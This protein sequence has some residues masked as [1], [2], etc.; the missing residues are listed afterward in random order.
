MLMDDDNHHFVKY[1]TGSFGTPIEAIRFHIDAE[2]GME[3]WGS[4]DRVAYNHTAQGTCTIAARPWAGT[5]ANMMGPMANRGLTGWTPGIQGFVDQPG[6]Y[7]L[8]DLMDACGIYG[9]TIVN[10][11]V[12]D[13]SAQTR[14]ETRTQVM[15]NMRWIKETFGH[16]A[17]V[18]V[19]YSTRFIAIKSTSGHDHVDFE[20]VDRIKDFADYSTSDASIGINHL[21]FEDP[22]H[23]RVI[24]LNK[25]T[26]SVAEVK[27]LM[28][29]ALA[30]G[31]YLNI[32]FEYVNDSGDPNAYSIAEFEE[33][34]DYGISIGLPMLSPLELI[35]KTGTYTL[36]IVGSCFD[37]AGVD[38]AITVPPDS[39]DVEIVRVVATHGTIWEVGDVFQE[40]AGIADKMI[41]IHEIHGLNK[42]KPLVVSKTRRTAGAGI[43]QKITID[44]VNDETTVERQ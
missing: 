12:G 34:L 13:E 7:T 28:D 23:V 30:S 9:W 32:V 15:N 24:I 6:M 43:D 8:Q 37:E 3:V 11:F 29:D 27:H 38:V 14:D 40:L 1:G 21:P 20:M 44:E 41:E 2:A 36:K 42:D 18:P 26:Y 10:A 22:Y 17:H 35:S 19:A 25:S 4:V 33:I 31:L 16:C 5:L 39:G